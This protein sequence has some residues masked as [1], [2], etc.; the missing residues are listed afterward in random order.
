MMRSHA[1]AAIFV[2]A[3]CSSA[4]VGA[5]SFVNGGFE[6][7]DFSGWTVG[8]NATRGVATAGTPF[9]GTEVA[10]NVV[11]PRSGDFAAFAHLQTNAPAT[12]LYIEQ[13][14]TGL[15]PGA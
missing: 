10:G 7:G 4:A 9:T 6:T 5:V 8:G 12:T 14:I 3:C 2:A 15:V 11:Q 13:T 1:I